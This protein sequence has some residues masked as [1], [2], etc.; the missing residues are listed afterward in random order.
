[1]SFLAAP[2]YSIRQM[3]IKGQDGSVWQYSFENE[4]KNP[5][6]S[7]DLFHFKASPGVQVVDKSRGN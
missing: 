6:I 3:T 7:D 5:P 4:K 2:D 1:V